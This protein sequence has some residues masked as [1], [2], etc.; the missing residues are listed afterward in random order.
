MMELAELGKKHA[1]L[2]PTP[3]Q[4]EQ[5]YLSS[6]YAKEGWFLSRS[7]YQLHL[8]QDVEAAMPY[9]GFPEMAKTKENVERL[10]RE[11]LAQ[12]LN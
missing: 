4:T 8:P 10:Y 3:G 5:E 9:R 11:V 6:Y 12:H 7:Q 1:L 2:T